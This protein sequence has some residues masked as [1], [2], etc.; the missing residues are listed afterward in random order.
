MSIPVMVSWL[1]RLGKYPHPCP[2]LPYAIYFPPRGN[3]RAADVAAFFGI[4]RYKFAA[5][6]FH[7]VIHS[8]VFLSCD[9]NL[10]FTG[11][12]ASS[13]CAVFRK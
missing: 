5:Q 4:Q 12:P 10:N 3:E 13:R 6:G 1:L 2:A 11:F 7:K 8:G 9:M